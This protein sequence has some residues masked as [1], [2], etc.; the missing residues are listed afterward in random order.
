MLQAGSLRSLDFGIPTFIP[1]EQNRRSKR[2]TET[3]VE[4]A[5]IFELVRVGIHTV[6]ETNRANRQ[7]VTQAST[8]RVAHV[9]Q[10][11]VLGG[12]QQIAS[13]SKHSAL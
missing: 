1:D 4:R 8:D 7:L 6:V 11:N 10:A 5:E 12:G 3:E 13:V 9:V 2:K